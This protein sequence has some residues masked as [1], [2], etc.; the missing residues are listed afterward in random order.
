[1]KQ[2]EEG[3]KE[4]KKRKISEEEEK[5]EEEEEKK[6]NKNKQ[7]QHT[8]THARM[9]MFPK[10]HTHSLT[11]SHSRARARTHQTGSLIV[12]LFSC[13]A[14]QSRRLHRPP[15]YCLSISSVI[16]LI[17]V[18]CNNKTEPKNINISS[19]KTLLWQEKENCTEAAQCWR[20]RAQKE[21]ERERERERESVFSVL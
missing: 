21:R 3:E 15:S 17:S 12:Q 16:L 7:Q 14:I 13:F 9:C 4:K 8:Q 18:W 2:K 20:H 19:G 6:N 1:M 10:K 11:H 5:E